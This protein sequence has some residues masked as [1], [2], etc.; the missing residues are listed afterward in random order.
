MFK[1]KSDEYLEGGM[2]R[3]TQLSNAA[4]VFLAVADVDRVETGPSMILTS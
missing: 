1:I 3:H 2:L 4:V